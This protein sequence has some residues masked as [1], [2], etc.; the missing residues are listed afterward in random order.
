[1]RSHFVFVLA[2]L[3][4]AV[5]GC[6]SPEASAPAESEAIAD[7]GPRILIVGGNASH[8][9]DRWFKEEDGATLEA[10]GAEVM[11]TDVADEVLPA[12][13]DIDIL[14][15]SNNQP[16]PDPAV[17]AAIF[18]HTDAGKGLLLAHPALWYNWADWPEYNRDLAG[19]GSRSHGKYGPFEVTVTQTDHP[20]MDGIPATFTTDDELYRYEVDTDGANMNVLAVGTEPDTGTQYPVVWTIDHPTRRIVCITL[21]HDGVTHEMAAYKT[22]LQ[23]SIAWLNR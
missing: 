11:Y 5:A 4:L 15:L 14:F 7:K 3:L 19:G 16:L 20:I 23:N 8:D 9:F 17:R 18:A 6:A 13:D 1:M 22:L 21:G 2:F 12:L 10:I